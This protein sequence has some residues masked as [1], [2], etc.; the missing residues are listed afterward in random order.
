M[1]SELRV[2]V[3]SSYHYVWMLTVHQVPEATGM[4]L[5]IY[6]IVYKVVNSSCKKILTHDLECATAIPLACSIHFL[7][8][9]YTCSTLLPWS[10]VTL[11]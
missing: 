1:Q 9:C 10:P 5:V 8:T 6:P 11:H 7:F 3:V 2:T 4:H